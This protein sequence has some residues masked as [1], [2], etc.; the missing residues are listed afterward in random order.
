MTNKHGFTLV[1]MLIS[2]LVAAILVIV[3]GKLSDLAMSSS[4]KTRKQLEVYNEIMDGYK[5]MQK[6]IREASSCGS[7]TPGS[8][9]W[10][11]NIIECPPNQPGVNGVAFGVWFDSGLSMR[12]LVFLKDKNDN[13]DR[14]VLLEVPMTSAFP[15]NSLTLTGTLSSGVMNVTISGEKAVTSR[16]NAIFA[17]P[18]SFT[19]KV[20]GR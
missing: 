2:L 11:G 19:T 6:H 13:T 5:I 9:T 20:K 15:N 14:E 8:G 3:I 16:N 4:A 10:V 17:T 12:Q 7:V 1:E 18:F